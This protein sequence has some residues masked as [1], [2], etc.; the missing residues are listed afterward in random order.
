MIMKLKLGI[1]TCPND[2]FMFEAL[3]NKRLSNNYFDFDLTM[4]DVEQLNQLSF[5]AEIDVTKISYHTYAYIAEN[6]QLLSAGSALGY[7]NGPLLISKLKI[8]PDEVEELKIAIPGKYTTANLLLSIAYPNVKEKKEYLF[9]DIEEAILS[10]E[11]DAGLIIHENRFTYQK[12]GLKKIIDLGQYW[13]NKTKLPI[14]LGGIAIRRK[15]NDDIKQKFNQQ[16]KRSI[17]FAFENTQTVLPF[18]KQHAQEMD[19]TVMKQHISLYVNEFSHNLGEKGEN[20][21]KKLYEEAFNQKRI[22]QI[23][24]NFIIK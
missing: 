11:V 21:I 23:P 17:K 14:P 2:T 6:Y 7:G 13:E 16:L 18:I 3:L 8:Y 24:E 5:A 12:K 10:N 22:K 19:E 15:L 9:S 20:A 1:S 4:T